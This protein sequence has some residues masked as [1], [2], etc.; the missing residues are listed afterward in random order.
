MRPDHAGDAGTSAPGR[1]G[2]SRAG[3][4]AGERG[5]TFTFAAG[6]R[7]RRLPGRCFTASPAGPLRA[8]DTAVRASIVC[9]EGALPSSSSST[10]ISS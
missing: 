2:T 10:T 5:D 6:A 3:V 7:N 9:S 8:S 1:P 4:P